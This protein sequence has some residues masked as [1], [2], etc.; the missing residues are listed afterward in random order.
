MPKDDY[1]YLKH[2]LD[3]IVKIKEYTKN[4]KYKKF[5][6]TMIVQDAVL[7][8]LGIIGEASKNISKELRERSP[9]IPWKKI[10]G[11]RDKLIHN[12]LGVDI[13]EIWNTIM[14]DISILEKQIEKI[15]KEK[16]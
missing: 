15:L 11:M 8:Q 7:R 5:V 2:I 14:K 4:L 3:A 16:K 12:Y 13:D 9:E 6:N 1:I 10:V